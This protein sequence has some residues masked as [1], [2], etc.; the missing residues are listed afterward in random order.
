MTGC[1]AILPTYQ[2]PSEGRRAKVRMIYGGATA[3]F[4]PGR[5]CEPAGN[6]PGL[7]VAGARLPIPGTGR[8]LNMPEPPAGRHFDE[9]FVRAGEPLTVRLVRRDETHSGSLTCA[10]PPFTFVPE[11]DAN[12]EIAFTIAPDFKSCASSLVRIVEDQPGNHRREPLSPRAPA[13]ACRN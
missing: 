1:S 8:K 13:S 4:F 9:V 3:K 7:D 11:P 6:D 12:Y 10:V 2:E 5:D